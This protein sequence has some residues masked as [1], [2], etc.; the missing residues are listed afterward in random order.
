MHVILLPL[1]VVCSGWVFCSSADHFCILVTKN[2]L[3]DFI[4]R[5]DVCFLKA[6][7]MGIAPMAF[8]GAQPINQTLSHSFGYCRRFVFACALPKEGSALN[9]LRLL[10]LMHN[11]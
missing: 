9:F 5:G 7:K 11:K 1:S 3:F 4:L 8:H 6:S 2:N 10:N